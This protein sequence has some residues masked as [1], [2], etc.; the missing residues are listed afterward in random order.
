MGLP[1]STVSSPPWAS[2]SPPSSVWAILK[3]HRRRA[4]TAASGTN[5]GGAPGRPSGGTEVLRL[6]PCRP[7]LSPQA[8]RAY[9]HPPRHPSRAGRRRHRQAGLRLGDPAGPQPL[10]GTRRAREPRQ[11]P[12]PRPRHQA[13]RFLRLSPRR[14]RPS[15]SSRPGPR[16]PG[17]TPS[18]NAPSA[19]TGASASTG[20]SYSAAASWRP[21]LPGTSSTTAP[22]DRTAP[23]ANARRLRSTR[24]RRR[25]A[26]S[27]PPSSRRAHAS[28]P[29]LTRCRGSTG[30][31]C[32]RTSHSAHREPLGG[33]AP[34]PRSVGRRPRCQ[35]LRNR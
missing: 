35:K 21:C 6:L 31:A 14:R 33:R 28:G 22:T 24:L 27:T 26:M 3:R 16:L 8:L 7:G 12:H 32:P 18:V 13:H 2:S 17:P 10:D 11:G 1:P 19:S 20:C 25:S 5:V 29:T 15:P 34:R 9:L 4:V 23:S 30:R